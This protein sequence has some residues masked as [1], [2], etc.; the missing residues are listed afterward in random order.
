MRKFQYWIRCV[1]DFKQSIRSTRSCD[2]NIFENYF[3]SPVGVAVKPS[4]IVLLR[5][6]N[7]RR[8]SKSKKVT[9]ILRDLGSK[10]RS[11][12]LTASDLD[13]NGEDPRFMPLKSIPKPFELGM[14]RLSSYLFLSEK[15][16]CSPVAPKRL[17]ERRFISSRESL[18]TRLTS[19][20]NFI[21]LMFVLSL[22]FELA[23]S[24]VRSSK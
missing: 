18:Y 4:L 7:F 2:L 24:T 22:L 15:S 20:N 6:I 14:L 3:C 12:H 8:F 17:V 5:D 16:E 23:K 21:Y 1:V 19:E 9:A 11:G 13:L 10:I